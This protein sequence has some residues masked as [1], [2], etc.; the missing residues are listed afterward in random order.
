MKYT[1][2]ATYYGG[3]RGTPIDCADFATARVMSRNL[4]SSP[5]VMSVKIDGPHIGILGRV[6]ARLSELFA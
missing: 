2:T 3:R 5:G 6:R 1:V 4:A